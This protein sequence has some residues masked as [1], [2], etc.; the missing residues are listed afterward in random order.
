[1][2]GVYAIEKLEECPLDERDIVL[3]DTV[4]DD[5]GVKVPA[6]A[7]VEH[8]VDVKFLLDNLV[9]GTDMWRRAGY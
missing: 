1:M 9:K 3:V 2:T 8:E 4:L 6:R 5:G 7:V